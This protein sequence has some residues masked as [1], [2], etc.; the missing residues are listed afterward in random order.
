M[1]ESAPGTGA[2]NGLQL[3]R[4]NRL[5]P[6][7]V[8]AVGLLVAA[9]PLAA[10]YLP[11]G[12]VLD[13][14]P[15]IAVFDETVKFALL[16]GG[17]SILLLCLLVAAAV[18][19]KQR[20]L[21]SPLW[22]PGPILLV[23]SAMLASALAIQPLRAL[24]S[25]W[26]GIVLPLLL[27]GL[28]AM[29]PLST[30]RVLSVVAIL[31]AA[32]LVVA[33]IGLLQA[34]E[35]GWADALPGIGTGSLL[36]NRNLA[37]E[38]VAVLLP[39]VLAPAF[40]D[41]A[42]RARGG[43]AA[44]GL[45]L[46]GYL[47][48]T[49][50]R[51]AWV[52]LLAGVPVAVLLLRTGRNPLPLKAYRWLALPAAL[53]A[54]VAA[55]SIGSPPVPGGASDTSE[56]RVIDEFRSIV[57]PA[58][59]HGRLEIWRDSLRLAVDAGTLGVG[60][61]EYRHHVVPYIEASAYGTDWNPATGAFRY[62]HRAH[63]D[64]LQL[65]IETGVGGLLGYLLIVLGV[66]VAGVRN[67]QRAQAAGDR[68]RC[69]LVIGALSSWLVLQAAMCFGF[70][71]QSPAT[72][73]TGALAA[74]LAVAPVAGSPR[75]RAP[76]RLPKAIAAMLVIG[77]SLAGLGLLM[78]AGQ[79]RGAVLAYQ[80]DRAYEQGRLPQAIHWARAA[81]HAWPWNTRAALA[82][83]RAEL[84][85]ADGQAALVSS[86]S[87]LRMEPNSPVAHWLVARAH[88]LVGNA[89][90]RNWHRAELASRF[91]HVIGAEAV[92]DQPAAPD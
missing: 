54:A 79:L 17:G 9:V 45:V 41:A 35:S 70:P 2:L 88:A 75:S 4:W 71:L 27:F 6:R 48:L 66:C 19:P 85:I 13:G 65:W 11:A 80:A 77:A 28:V 68:T 47:V 20:R 5:G 42:P 78:A 49:M 44:A 12:A 62:P 43:V 14:T 25:A 89:A 72:L 55:S 87:L 21:P 26:Q 58:A 39:L 53:L 37:G 76:T 50:A 83:T 86:R 24:G 59:S 61:G 69:Q 81:Q 91:G 60:A 7:G 63:N 84:A 16:Q 8:S 33:V 56:R 46:V 73:A 22:L 38:Y 32:G 15:A 51:G 30:R 3:P 10:L 40:A 82:Q 57:D 52:G 67:A 23:L 36:Y 64:F 90:A 1:T 74:A 29:Q 31:R 34:F 18:A 92:G